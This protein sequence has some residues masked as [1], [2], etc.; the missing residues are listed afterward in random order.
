MP[1]ENTNISEFNQCQ[2]SDKT[3]SVIYADLESLINRLDG[4]K[5]KPEKLSTR[6][7][8]FHV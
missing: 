2:I 5:I 6:E 7:Q 3:P 4:C 1:S 8:V